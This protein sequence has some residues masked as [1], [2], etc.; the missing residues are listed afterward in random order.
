MS[1]TP[2]EEI[3]HVIA[4][5]S[6]FLDERR[7]KEFS[8][9]FTVDGV[10][11]GRGPRDA[12]Y[13]GI[14]K[15]EL[16]VNAELKRNHWVDNVVIDVNGDEA[17]ATCDMMQFDRYGDKPWVMRCAQYVDRL[18]KRDGRWQFVERKLGYLDADR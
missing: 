2:E 10:G 8:E 4:Q 6:H 16:A 9:F 14:S 1:S 5:F 17:T 15:G 3:R 18:V 11:F 12:V 13:E 7:F